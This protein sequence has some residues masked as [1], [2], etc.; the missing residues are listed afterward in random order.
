MTHPD[1]EI[2]AAIAL[3]E[4]V[5]DDVERHVAD[6]IVCRREV[7]DL[8]AALS[9]AQASRAV[10][11]ARPDDA[12]W[13]RINAALDADPGEAGDHATSDDLAPRRDR[14]TTRPAPQGNRGR[15]QLPWILGAAA[16]GL[17]IGGVGASVILGGSDDPAPSTVVATTPLKTLDTERADGAADLERRGPHVD[18]AVRT[19]ALDAGSGYLEV[20]LINSDMQRMV[21]VGVLPSDATEK[22]FPIPQALIDQGYVIVD[23]SRENFDD[24]PQH[25][26]DSLLRGTLPT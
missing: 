16:A 1:D 23:I 24:Q 9:H 4:D 19:G 14:R 17:V 22:R 2:L 6:C 8:G 3:G 25:S 18:L 21:S 5:P 10:T 7:A 26:G 13:D 20:W 15:R 12:V 11:L